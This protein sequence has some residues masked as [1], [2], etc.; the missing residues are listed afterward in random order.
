M[1]RTPQTNA[2]PG[3]LNRLRHLAAARALLPYPEPES[4]LDIG[5]GYGYFPEAAKSVFPYTAFDGLDTDPRVEWARAAERIDEAHHGTL[6][7]PD[8]AGR[9]RARYDVVSMLDHLEHTADPHEE[10]RAALTALRPDGHLLVELPDPARG[11]GGRWLSTGGR[12]R[13]PHLIP[14]RKLREELESLGCAVVAARACVPLLPYAYRVIA[15]RQPRRARRQPRR[16]S[17]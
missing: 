5:T 7:D 16:D 9:L 11:L 12:P 6:T 1:P 3:R 17:A 10:L 4:W 8:T 15:R 13:P 2:A 14:A